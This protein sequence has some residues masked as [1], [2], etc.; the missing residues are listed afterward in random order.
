MDTP[1]R[2]EGQPCS[3]WNKPAIIHKWDALVWFPALGD[4]AGIPRMPGRKNG[5]RSA[6]RW[7]SATGCVEALC[8]YR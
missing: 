3:A 4:E 1:A 8:V 7:G 2:A 5:M 6:E